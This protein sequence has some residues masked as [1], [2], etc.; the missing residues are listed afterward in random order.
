MPTLTEPRQ[1]SAAVRRCQVELERLGFSIRATVRQA[2]RFPGRSRVAVTE[3]VTEFQVSR[4]ATGSCI[5]PAATEGELL[6]F[7]VGL[8]SG[9]ILNT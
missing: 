3:T 4:R 1:V 8:E 6:A 5:L 9:R 2:R 7:C